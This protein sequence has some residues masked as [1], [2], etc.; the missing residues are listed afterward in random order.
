M[1]KT[2]ELYRNDG[3]LTSIKVKD[4]AY[5]LIEFTITQYLK[6]G[7]KEIVNNAYTTFYTSR[8]MKEFFEP[9][10]NDLKVRFNDA[11]NASKP[12]P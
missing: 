1:D 6:T 4:H 8:E 7:E 2:Y 11:D 12:N 5:D 10:I 3:L 9:I